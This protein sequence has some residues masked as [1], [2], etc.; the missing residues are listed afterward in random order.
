MIVPAPEADAV[1]FAVGVSPDDT[2]WVVLRVTD[3]E[4][5]ADGRATPSYAAAGGAIAYASPFYLTPVA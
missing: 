4:R 5:P 1:R 3:P 2:S